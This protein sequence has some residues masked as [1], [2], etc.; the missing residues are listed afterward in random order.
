MVKA[1]E[2]ENTYTARSG[3][4][5]A[6][7]KPL[8][9]PGE[10]APYTFGD[11]MEVR[12]LMGPKSRKEEARKLEENKIS[13]RKRALCREAVGY[14]LREV[15]RE[16]GMAEDIV[17]DEA[18]EKGVPGITGGGI[19]RM[20]KADLAIA[21][22]IHMDSLPAWAEHGRG[23]GRGKGRGDRGSKPARGGAQVT[24][25]GF[26][27]RGGGVGG[28][29]DAGKYRGRGGRGGG[30]GRGKHSDFEW[31]GGNTEAVPERKG[32]R[33][34]VTE[35]RL[36]DEAKKVKLADLTSEPSSSSPSSAPTPPAVSANSA[37]N[38]P[39]TSGTAKEGGRKK[40]LLGQ[41]LTDGRVDAGKGYGLF[42]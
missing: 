30:R 34:I 17:R 18:M 33:K 31:T 41:L 36:A 4:P 9:G 20:D 23:R 27:S 13:R 22:G 39:S 14:G 28:R 38:P 19:R 3:R 37:D 7:L 21:R 10:A 35:E 29:G 40:S 25:G 42:D 12:A 32:K 15:I 11:V 16:A 5:A 26:G 6:W 24:R 2:A 1:G 8:Q